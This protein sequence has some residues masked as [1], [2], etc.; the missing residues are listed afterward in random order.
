MRS[1][2]LNLCSQNCRIPW[3]LRGS[4]LAFTVRTRNFSFTHHI[5]TVVSKEDICICLDCSLLHLFAGPFGD[6]DDQQ[7]FVQKVVPDTD[8]LFVRHSYS[9]K[10]FLSVVHITVVIVFIVVLEIHVL[11]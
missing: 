6:R 9:G 8:R 3:A 11:S 2:S 10:R 7:V 4:L 1:E 5:C